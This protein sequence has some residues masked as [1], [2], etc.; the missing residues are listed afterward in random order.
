LCYSNS[1]TLYL[2][3]IFS[4]VLVSISWYHFSI[5]IYFI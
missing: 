3:I 2:G 4:I 5:I 1:V